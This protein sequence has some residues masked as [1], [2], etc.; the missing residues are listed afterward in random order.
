MI[1][2]A[3]AGGCAAVVSPFFVPLSAPSQPVEY[4]LRQCLFLSFQ[5]GNTVGELLMI[6]RVYPTI[7]DEFFLETITSPMNSDKCECQR[8]VRSDRIDELLY[9]SLRVLYMPPV[10]AVVS[11][12]SYRF[13]RSYTYYSLAESGALGFAASWTRLMAVLQRMR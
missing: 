5:F 3:I 8:L 10:Y 11:F 9:V 12:F 4:I 13:F 7:I 6:C 1:G 2:W